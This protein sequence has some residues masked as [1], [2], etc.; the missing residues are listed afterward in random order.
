MLWEWYGFPQWIDIDEFLEK[1]GGNVSCNNRSDKL[2]Y[3]NQIISDNAIIGTNH[4]LLK[5]EEMANL[6]SRLEKIGESVNSRREVISGTNS[7]SKSSKL[8]RPRHRH[9]FTFDSNIQNIL[10]E[11]TVEEFLQMDNVEVANVS[12]ERYNLP[13]DTTRKDSAIISGGINISRR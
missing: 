11:P 12:F 8:K 2:S 5:D 10:P 13:D 6:S 9:S 7:P 1:F 3:I 4:V